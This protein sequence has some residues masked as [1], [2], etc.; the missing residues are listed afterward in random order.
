[1]RRVEIGLLLLSALWC[2]S[3]PAEGSCFPVA[4]RVQT[5]QQVQQVSSAAPAV[6]LA[7]PT[8]PLYIA[9]FYQDDTE[10]RILKAE[11][12]ATNAELRA[13]RAEML[14]GV[15]RMGYPNGNGNGNG[16]GPEEPVPGKAVAPQAGAGLALCA[17]CHEAGVAKAKGAG[18]VFFKKNEAVL[19]PEQRGQAIEEVLV[20]RMPKGTKLA[21]ESKLKVIADLVGV[22]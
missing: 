16:G 1:M 6:Q 8:Y 15:P 17:A 12:R 11:L 20:G 4:R 14:R 21:P 22:K 7:P 13:L 9:S 10:L 2:R 18:H 3:T 19:T 5:V